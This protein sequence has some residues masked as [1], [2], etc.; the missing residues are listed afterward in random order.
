MSTLNLPTDPWAFLTKDQV[1]SVLEAG[2]P[3]T[4]QK[5]LMKTDLFTDLFTKSGTTATIGMFGQDDFY[6]FYLK[7]AP[8]SS[9]ILSGNSIIVWFQMGDTASPWQGVQYT[10]TS[11]LSSSATP[12]AMDGVSASNTDYST[13]TTSA[14]GD[15]SFFYG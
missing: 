5:A 10:A 8:A 9:L 1:L 6:F 15:V 12:I 2:F 7:F 14:Y 11:A 4:E 13:Q 3:N